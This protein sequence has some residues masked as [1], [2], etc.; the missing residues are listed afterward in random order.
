MLAIIQARMSS[1]RL[2]GKVLLPL[3]GKPIL[4]RVYDRLTASNQ[5]SEIVVSTSVS[6]SDTL[7]YEYCIENSIPVHRG[8]LND[9]VDRLLGCAEDRRADHFVRISGDSPLIDP[10]LID[11]VVALQRETLCDLATNVQVRSFPKG[12]SVEVIRTE[13]LGH[14]WPKMKLAEDF[15]HVTRYFY[16]HPNDF[17]IENLLCEDAIGD[18]QLSVDTPED[19]QAIEEILPKLSEFFSWR[20]AVASMQG[21]AR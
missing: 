12:Q 2:P 15:E 11:R 19:L 14:A 10:T 4:S 8:S 1:T 18:L 16:A 9:V 6:T 13:S 21:E 17:T 5:L 7:I 3:A 20:D